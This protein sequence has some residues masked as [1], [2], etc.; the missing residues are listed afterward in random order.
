LNGPLSYGFL[1]LHIHTAFQS[2]GC[3]NMFALLD[4]SPAVSIRGMSKW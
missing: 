4:S 3:H 2:K 1:V